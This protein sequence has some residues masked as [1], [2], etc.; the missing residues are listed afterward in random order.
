MN[1]KLPYIHKG[2][3]GRINFNPRAQAQNRLLM[4]IF[5]GAVVIFFVIMGM[6][7]FQLTIVK[8]NYYRSLSDDNRIREV[9][10]EARRGTIVD[11]KGYVIAESNEAD[12]QEGIERVRSQR[13][14]KDP[15]IFAHI[16][17]YRQIAD[18]KDSEQDNCLNKIKLGDKVG[19]K[20]IEKLFDCEL[21]GKNGKKLVEVNAQGGMERTLHV[22]EPEP[23]E[24]I[25]LSI[26][27]DLQIR[28]HQ[29]LEGKKGVIVAADPRTG[30]VLTL[31]STPSYN[32]Q[33]F[34]DNNAE[35]ISQLFQ[36][37]ERPL[38]NRATEGVYPPG[39]V[40]KMVV[41]A[42]ALEEGTIDEDDTIY[43]SGKLE[44]GDRSFGTWNY[45]EHGQTEGDVDVIESLRRSNDIFYYKVAE[46]M[47]PEKIK[48]WAEIF[49]YNQLSGIGISEVEGTIPSPFWKEETIGEQWYTGDTYNFSI[50]QGYVLASPLQVTL[51]TIPFANGG[52]YCKPMLVKTENGL[53][54][55]PECTEVPMSEET[56][57]IVREGMHQACLPG[58][59]GWPLFNFT[60]RDA[61]EPM[62]TPKIAS[63]AAGLGSPVATPSGAIAP[64]AMPIKELWDESYLVSS[65]AAYLRGQPTK[66]IE[67]GCKSG[68]AESGQGND[69]HAWFTVFAP[70]DDPE[71]IITVL[72][73]RAGQGS[74]M[75][76]PAAREMLRMYFERME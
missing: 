7:L 64:T 33:V 43:D 45:L 25:P 69:P 66:Q 6:R 53:G 42:A 38:F 14:Y 60:V 26:D 71:I 63:D 75:A 27:G 29:L 16:I 23:G 36:D 49:K 68:T 52:K 22:V 2:D 65:S 30:E 67:L 74:D 10:I 48:K 54:I 11:R 37:E 4:Y 34:E 72:L 56:L 3:I 32:P 57:G 70:Y 61:G 24:E 1:A 17:G 46:Q 76:A 21:R 50:G 51:A 59:T 19:K 47:G 73:E 12:I 55:E 28:A 15:E 9:T 41:A 31:A 44:L 18:E 8:G 39:S 62:P 35:A 13:H 40:F 20:G 58:G 5:F